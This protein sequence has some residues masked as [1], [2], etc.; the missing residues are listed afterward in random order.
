LRELQCSAQEV[1][2]HEFFSAVY[3]TVNVAFKFGRAES[4]QF[5]VEIAVK[6]GIAK[7]TSHG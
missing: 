7:I 4:V 1:L 3:A 2:G 6:E 5:T